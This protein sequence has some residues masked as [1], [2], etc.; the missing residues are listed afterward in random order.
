MG[1]SPKYYKRHFDVYRKWEKK[2]GADIVTR[3]N[4]RSILDLGCGV[5][6]YLEGALEAGAETVS[7]IEFNWELAKTYIPESVSKFI[8]QGDVTIQVPPLYGSFDLTMSVEV[9]EHIDPKEDKVDAF[10]HNLVSTSHN[11]IILTAAPPGQKGTNHVNCRP[12]EFWIEK[13][14]GFKHC[15]FVYKD[16]YVSTCKEAWS[17]FGTANWVLNNLMIFQKLG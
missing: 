13:L 16:D 8:K 17:K 3:F 4:A 7:G 6:S 15:Q 11:I 2:I 9:A 12:R 14:T 1:Y 10:I 5:G